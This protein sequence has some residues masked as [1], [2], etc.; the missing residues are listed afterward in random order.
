M[1]FYYETKMYAILFL[2]FLFPKI[3]FLLPFVYLSNGDK[4]YFWDIAN[5]NPGDVTKFHL[6]KGIS[7][8]FRGKNRVKIAEI[9]KVIICERR[10]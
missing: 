3:S 4:H 6:K 5:V 7:G 9:M 10:I 1:L 8:V 2:V